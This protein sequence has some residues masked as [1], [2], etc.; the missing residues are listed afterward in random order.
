MVCYRYVEQKSGCSEYEV[1]GMF[2]I[3]F[4]MAQSIDGI[5]FVNYVLVLSTSISPMVSGKVGH[6]H[7]PRTSLI[8]WSGHGIRR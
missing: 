4:V 7:S 2:L 6:G 1:A 5:S 3:S 8:R